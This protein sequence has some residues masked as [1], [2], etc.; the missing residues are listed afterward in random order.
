M[1]NHR[2]DLQRFSKLSTNTNL[3]QTQHKTKSTSG[4]ISKYI[5]SYAA[6]PL[7]LFHLEFWDDPLAARSMLLC[8]LLDETLG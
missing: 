6:C 7:S 3:Q 5:I 1:I 4:N 8:Q 2:K